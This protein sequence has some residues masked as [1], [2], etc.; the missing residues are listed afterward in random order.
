VRSN[1]KLRTEKPNL[2]IQ[3]S[4][5]GKVQRHVENREQ[6]VHQGFIEWVDEEEIYN[7][8]VFNPD[9]P[10]KSVRER[11]IRKRNRVRRASTRLDEEIE[12]TVTNRNRSKDLCFL[13]IEIM[14]TT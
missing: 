3:S 10:V 2:I 6:K 14:N 8:K 1:H 4:F 12:T 13:H 11:T 9:L 7:K 5:R